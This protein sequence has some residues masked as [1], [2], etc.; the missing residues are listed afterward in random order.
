VV[1]G[2]DGLRDMHICQAITA[3]CAIP[4]F[5][6]PYDIQGR[7]YLD[8]STGKSIHL[9][10]AVERGAELIVLVN[11]RVPLRNDPEHFCLPSLSYGKCASI[12]DLGISI[13]QEQARRIESREK[14]SLTLDRFRN[15]H[16]HVD[17]VLIEPERDE[18]VFFF[19]NPMSMRARNHIMAFGYQLTLSQLRTR[20]SELRET[21]QRHGIALNPDR[22]EAPPPVDIH[23]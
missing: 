21:F 19:Q 22:L 14:I 15:S 10:I 4:H 3:S 1:F 9:D 2:S 12:A 6:R 18:S 16:P 23:L 7:R 8:G 5:F 11:P 20:F 13:A 17:I